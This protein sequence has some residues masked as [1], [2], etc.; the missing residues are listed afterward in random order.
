MARWRHT[1]G[2]DFGWERCVGSQPCHGVE[3]APE[4]ESAM[5]EPNW[6][7]PSAR[8]ALSP[9]QRDSSSHMTAEVRSSQEEERGS[10]PP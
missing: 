4:E 8:S 3:P 6:T 5:S 1:T 2:F 9:S 7:V 10:F